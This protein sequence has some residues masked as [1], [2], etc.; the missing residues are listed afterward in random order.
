MQKL[1]ED[2]NNGGMVL[3]QGVGQLNVNSTGNV[4]P[5]DEIEKHRS[6]ERQRSIEMEREKVN[7]S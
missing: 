7:A 2:K 3:T 5:R 6:Y 1:N 4:S